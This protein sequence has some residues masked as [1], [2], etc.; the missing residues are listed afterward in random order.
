ME[1]AAE[2]VVF[3]NKYT[4]EPTEVILGGDKDLTG[5]KNIAKGDYYFNLYETNEDFEVLKD[6]VPVQTTQNTDTEGTF[7]FDK[8]VFD[9]AGTYYYVI[10][11]NATQHLSQES[12][13]TK[14]HMK[15]RLS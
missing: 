15:L 1:S 6:A 14:A 12:S 7:A 11:E 5:P 9:K 2:A 10:S 3:E 8:L 4:T 13:M